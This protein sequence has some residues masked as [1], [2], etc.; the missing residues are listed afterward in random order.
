MY[1]NLLITNYMHTIG[2]ILAA[3]TIAISMSLTV[4]G[5]MVIVI[6]VWA[7]CD[8]SKGDTIEHTHSLRG[9]NQMDSICTYCTGTT[10][11]CLV[12]SASVVGRRRSETRQLGPE[13]GVTGVCSAWLAWSCMQREVEPAA[14]DL[15][16]VWEWVWVW[17]CGCVV[18]CLSVCLV[19]IL[20][21]TY[22]HTCMNVR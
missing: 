2:V 15:P 10:A 18:S 8:I 11:R 22:I 21:S 19:C 13:P 9:T 16:C 14:A 12:W 20:R 7:E 17:M 1:N 6:V 4:A 3:V 5:N